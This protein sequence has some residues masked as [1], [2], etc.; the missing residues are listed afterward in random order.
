MAKITPTDE[1]NY[2]GEPRQRKRYA[3]IDEEELER[4]SRLHLTNT[5]IAQWFNCDINTLSLEP[6]RTI[7]ANGKSETKQRL[8][9][10]IIQRALIDNSD[11][12]LI[13]ALKNYCGW[14]DNKD[15][16]GD[17]PPP[18]LKL[19]FSVPEVKDETSDK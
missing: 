14:G 12:A 9:Q 17:T 3:T 2:K 7:I 1:L 13:F 19:E 15:K 11:T 18:V 10:K 16:A 5:E 6:Y 8:K 4:M